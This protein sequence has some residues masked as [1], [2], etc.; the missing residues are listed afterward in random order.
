VNPVPLRIDP[1]DLKRH[2]E[3]AALIAKKLGEDTAPRPPERQHPYRRRPTA[4]REGAAACPGSAARA[5]RLA[6]EGDA[7][8]TAFLW[9]AGIALAV[10]AAGW[11]APAYAA[12]SHV[13]AGL[14]A[15]R[16][17]AAL[18]VLA[19]GHEAAFRACRRLGR[20]AGCAQVGLLSLTTLVAGATA[21]F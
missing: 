20:W 3:L 2:P 6:A 17:W 15:Y 13:A 12:L 7:T 8:R 10:A 1:G 4:V 9:T 19:L 16:G 18:A 11:T 14:G 21:G 5:A